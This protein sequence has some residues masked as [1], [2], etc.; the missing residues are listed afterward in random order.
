MTQVAQEAK[1]AT[2]GE[3]VTAIQQRSAALG[4]LLKEAAANENNPDA[5]RAILEKL[6]GSPA[7]AAD[8]SPTS[9]IRPHEQFKLEVFDS[10]FG[11]G[12]RFVQPAG[13]TLRTMM[14]LINVDSRNSY[15]RD[16]IYRGNL[17]KDGGIDTPATENIVHE[18]TPVVQG[19]ENRSRGGQ[20]DYMEAKGMSFTDRPLITI[21]A[22]LF[23][24]EKG[25]PANN[26]DIGTE[27]DK[28]DLLQGKVVRARSGA[29]ASDVY[30]LGAYD[31]WDDLASHLVV[32]AG[33]PN[34]KS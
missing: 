4:E 22:G 9:S 23:R 30:G 18:F 15:G 1:T 25:F 12:V 11:Q 2:L 10:K 29:L 33:S 24:L 5:L 20:K 6:D 13:M 34:Q 17:L 16:A 21:A 26:A 3:V 7:T 28:G 31:Y 32:A 8:V 14:D 19:S 27:R